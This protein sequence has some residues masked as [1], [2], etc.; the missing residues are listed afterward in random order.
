MSF[1]QRT[2]GE[3]TIL[4]LTPALVTDVSKDLFQLSIES[5]LT[6]GR[7]QILLNLKELRW[8]NSFALGLVVAAH[9]SVD[10]HGGRMALCS[11]N[12]RV[13]EMLKVVGLS[14]VW[15][16]HDTEDA[17]LASFQDQA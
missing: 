9:R 10:E 2:E 12:D 8:M 5:L 16:I 4:D 11:P 7:D 13:L 15:E 1:E 3:V 14:Q 6:N 17:A